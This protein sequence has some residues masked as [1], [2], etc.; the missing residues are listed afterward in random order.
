MSSWR[1][2]IQCWILALCFFPNCRIGVE[3]RDQRG[4]E[5]TLTAA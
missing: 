1:N 4:T 3:C 5:F 2:D